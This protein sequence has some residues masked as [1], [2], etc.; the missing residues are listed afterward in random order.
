MIH[1]L[2]IDLQL[3]LESIRNADVKI[4]TIMRIKI[5]ILQ[6]NLNLSSSDSQRAFISSNFYICEEIPGTSKLQKILVTI[7]T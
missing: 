4:I 2:I 6:I 7:T 1:I 3:T 5:I